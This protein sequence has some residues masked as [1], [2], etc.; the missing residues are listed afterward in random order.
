[1]ITNTGSNYLSPDQLASSDGVDVIGEVVGVKVVSTGANYEEGDLIVSES[2]ETMVPK[3]EDGRIVGGDGKIDQGLTRVPKLFLQTNTGIGAEVLPITRFV[4]RE[5]Y[6][7]PI[8]PDAELITVIS[9]PR[10][11]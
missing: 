5:D 10:F 8:V 4:K 2:G 6:T 11:Y 3:I 1:V 7:D 9:C